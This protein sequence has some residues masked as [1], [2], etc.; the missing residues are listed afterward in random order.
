MNNYEVGLVLSCMDYRLIDHVVNFL[1]NDVHVDTFDFTVLAGASLGFNQNK[2]LTWP[3]SFKNHVDLAIKLH[4]IKK[5]VVIDHEDCGAYKAFYPEVKDNIPREDEYHVKHIKSMEK[6]YPDLIYAGY[7]MRLD[8][9][10]M[11]V[12]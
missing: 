7:L 9:K 5:V 3:A 10:A 2:Y 6:M 4:K 1:K 11:K 12:V 8:G